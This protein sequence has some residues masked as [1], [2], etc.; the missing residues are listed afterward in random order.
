MVEYSHENEEEILIVIY[1]IDHPIK[2]DLMHSLDS[3]NAFFAYRLPFP[4]SLHSF[5]NEPIHKAAMVEKIKIKHGFCKMDF[6][7]PISS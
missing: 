5:P 7:S 4:Q 6:L 2:K 1:R 3:A